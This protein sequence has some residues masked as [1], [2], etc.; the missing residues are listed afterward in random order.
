MLFG[1]F[2]LLNVINICTIP[3]RAG[4]KHAPPTTVSGI[5]GVLTSPPIDPFKVAENGLDHIHAMANSNHKSVVVSILPPMKYELRS[6]IIDD[7]ES[8]FDGEYDH[9]LDAMGGRVIEGVLK[10]LEDPVLSKWIIVALTIS[11]ALNGYLFNAARWSVKDPR[12]VHFGAGENTIVHERPSV[13]L[14]REDP[15]PLDTAQLLQMVM[16]TRPSVPWLKRTMMKSER[17]LTVSEC[18]RKG[19]LPS[20]AI[21]SS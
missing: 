17:R 7:G 18:S 20:L 3:F 16:Q 5:Q 10:S 15:P 4:N 1:G 14:L 8:S 6:T 12:S 11:L 21:E 9:L 2:I 13:P 19:G